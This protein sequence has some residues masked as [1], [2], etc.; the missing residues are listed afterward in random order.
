MEQVQTV[1]ALED[2][3]VICCWFTHMLVVGK[4]SLIDNAIIN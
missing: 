1:T 3:A 4:D 2:M